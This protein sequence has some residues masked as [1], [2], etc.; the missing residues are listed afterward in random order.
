MPLRN[1][2]FQTSPRALP[3]NAVAGFYTLVAGGGGTMAIDLVHGVNFRLLLN[4]T[5]YTLLA[6]TYTGGAIV[7][8]MRISIYAEQ[9]ATGQRTGPTYTTG[10]GGF[11]NDQDLQQIDPTP[12]RR[13]KLEVFFDG[14]LGCSQGLR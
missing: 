10:A 4:G 14:P 8:G 13:T 12:S 1:R 9:D 3:L 11:A 5:L 2:T 7:A 6:P